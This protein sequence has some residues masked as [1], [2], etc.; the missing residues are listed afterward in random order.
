MNKFDSLFDKILLESEKYFR[1][2]Q[3][4]MEEV[5]IDILMKYAEAEIDDGN[6]QNF[7]DALEDAIRGGETKIILRLIQNDNRISDT[8]KQYY[9]SWWYNHRHELDIEHVIKDYKT[10]ELLKSKNVK[11]EDMQTGSDLLDV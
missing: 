8:V 11:P 2:D 1:V 5:I 9:K 4:E 10:K 3:K 7:Y 6:Y